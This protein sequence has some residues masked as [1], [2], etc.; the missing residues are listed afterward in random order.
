MGHVGHMYYQHRIR[1]RTPFSAV[2]K[3]LVGGFRKDYGGY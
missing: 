2:D 3:R 1:C